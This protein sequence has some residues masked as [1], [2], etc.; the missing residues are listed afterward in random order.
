VRAL[1]SPPK[2][3]PDR[4]FFSPGAAARGGLGVRSAESAIMTEQFSE[5]MKSC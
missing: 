1:A 4:A 2:G 3:S 5:G